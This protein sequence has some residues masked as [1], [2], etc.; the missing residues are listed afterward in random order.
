MSWTH[1]N[2]NDQEKMV[3]K[4][5]LLVDERKSHEITIKMKVRANIAKIRSIWLED[6]ANDSGGY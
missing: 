4:N 2:P 6:M 3:A 1:S 5:I